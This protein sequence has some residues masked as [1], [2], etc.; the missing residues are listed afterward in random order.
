MSWHAEAGLQMQF[1]TS[2][3]VVGTW[4][5]PQANKDLCFAEA[6]EKEAGIDDF[7]YFGNFWLMCDIPAEVENLKHT[8]IQGKC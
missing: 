7:V 2:P 1:I 8:Q 4:K 5:L 3:E 6:L